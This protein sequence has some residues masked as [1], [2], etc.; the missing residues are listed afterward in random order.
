MTEEEKKF[1]LDLLEKHEL[2][3]YSIIFLLG[4]GAV[5]TAMY[6]TTTDNESLERAMFDLD[7]DCLSFLKSH[8]EE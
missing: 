3:L 8:K 7:M 6:A 1:L 2:S 5:R 4:I